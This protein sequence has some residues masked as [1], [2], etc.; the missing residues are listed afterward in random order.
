ML[1][2]HATSG[3][4]AETIRALPDDGNRYEI[5]GGELFVTPAP[6][7]PHQ[8][9]VLALATLV[10]QYVTVQGLGAAIIAPA[11][12]E[13][14]PRTLV[15]PDI[16]VVPLVEGRKPRRWED[17]GR[18]LLAIEILSPPSARADRQV[19]RHLY[20]RMDVPEYWIVDIDARV[21]ERWRPAD[22]RPE[23]L[24]DEL[25]W[26]PVAEHPALVIELSRLF[27]GV[28]GED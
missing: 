6:S 17:V 11:E 27:A 4:T 10:S 3:W 26:Q 5:I 19:K 24:A 9:A 25:R 2:P 15:E 8:A 14:E 16:F 18:L 22:E 20:Q 21:I 12:I 13:L 7:W 28:W 1:M 23:I